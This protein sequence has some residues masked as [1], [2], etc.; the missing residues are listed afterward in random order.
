MNYLP[1]IHNRTLYRFGALEAGC[2]G[3]LAL[4]KDGR[5]LAYSH[6]NEH[7]YR[8]EDG[9]LVFLNDK[10]EVTNRLRHGPESNVFLS[11]GKP[12]LYLLPLLSL[13]RG[14]GKKNLPPVFVNSIPKSGTYFLEAAFARLG[15]VP[16]RLHLGS[17]SCH[18]YR[19]VPENEMHRQPDDHFLPVPAGA[20]AALMRPGDVAVGHVED[21]AQLDAISEAG[22]RV[23][24]AVR[25]LREVLI[26]LYRFKRHKVAPTSPADKIWRGMDEKAGFLAFLCHFEARDIA[27]ISSMASTVIARQEPTLRYEHITLG[28]L[29]S[30]VQDFPDLSKA[31]R[32][33]RGKPTSTLLRHD[34]SASPWSEAAEDFF[35]ASGLAKLNKDLG[36]NA[37]S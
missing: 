3:Y 24:H 25:D 15:A 14:A 20:I 28:E 22:V 9:F 6:P 27:F 5:I 32:E 19:G 35:Q 29:P 30:K 16:L 1:A 31:L 26:S 33:A 34:E 18:D 11:D 2:F 10:K 21:H 7:S 4:A 12:F 37:Q 13:G 8:L 36:Y 17:S 23:L